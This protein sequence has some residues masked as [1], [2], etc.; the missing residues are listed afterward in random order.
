MNARKG[1]LAA[2]IFAAATLGIIMVADQQQARRAAVLVQ[3][4]PDSQ[5]SDAIQVFQKVPT[6]AFLNPF[7]P[8]YLN[9][10]NTLSPS[11]FFER[12]ETRYQHGED[13]WVES[14]WNRSS[15]RDRQGE[16]RA[17]SEKAPGYHAPHQGFTCECI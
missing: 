13:G 1:A 10:T 11:A 5:I 4:L 16:A 14:R 12:A 9:A 2:L 8:P 6:T 7:L 17:R 3:L 15:R